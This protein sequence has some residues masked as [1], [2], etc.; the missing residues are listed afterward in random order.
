MFLDDAEGAL[1]VGVLTAV[2]SVYAAVQAKRAADAATRMVELE[3]I[4]NAARSS[5]EDDLPALVDDLRGVVALAVRYSR[6]KDPDA[7][8]KQL[9]RLE[10]VERRLDEQRRRHRMLLGRAEGAV[11]TLQTVKRTV[12]HTRGDDGRTKLLLKRATRLREAI[13]PVVWTACT[14]GEAPGWSAA[15]VWMLLYS[16]YFRRQYHN[17]P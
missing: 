17:G 3:G 16:W 9:A 1:L 7:V 10:E 14:R 2:V 4:R 11:H 5:V 13:D 6:V 12:Q 8:A 15:M